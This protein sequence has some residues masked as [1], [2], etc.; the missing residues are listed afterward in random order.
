MKYKLM[1]R[2]GFSID[3]GKPPE[4]AVKRGPEKKQKIILQ[5]QIELL[6]VS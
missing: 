6:I 2:D 1:K 5:M 4:H 3:T